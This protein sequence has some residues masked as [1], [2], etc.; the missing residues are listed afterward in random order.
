[1]ARPPSAR[2]KAMSPG[3]ESRPKTR[4]VCS[5]VSTALGLGLLDG[6]TIRARLDPQCRAELLTQSLEADRRREAP[7]SEVVGVDDQGRRPGCHGVRIP[8]GRPALN[9][10]LHANS[11]ARDIF[12]CRV[13]ANPHHSKRS[14]VEHLRQSAHWH[15]ACWEAPPWSSFLRSWRPRSP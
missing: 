10:P 8:A 4:G 1:M 12:S 5:M 7:G 6:G 3:L 9:P 14:V 13:L 2:S 11:Y 15:V